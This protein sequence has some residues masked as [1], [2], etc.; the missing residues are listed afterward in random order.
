M[1]FWS[2]GRHP[3]ETEDVCAPAKTRRSRAVQLQSRWQEVMERERRA[4]ARNRR[5][6]QDFQKAQ[7]TLRDLAARTAAMATIRMEYERQLEQRFPQWQ[8]RFE[9][10]RIAAEQN[11]QVALQLKEALRAVKEKGKGEAHSRTTKGVNAPLSSPGPSLLPNS[12]ILPHRLITPKNGE[13]HLHSSQEKSKV[14]KENSAENDPYTQW[15]VSVQSS[16]MTGGHSRTGV[17]QASNDQNIHPHSDLRGFQDLVRAGY[18]FQ[19]PL[20]PLVSQPVDASWL[21]PQE[22]PHR[23]LIMGYPPGWPGLCNVPRFHSP[24]SQVP[25]PGY[26][27]VVCRDWGMAVPHGPDDREDSTRRERV[28]SEGQESTKDSSQGEQGCKRQMRTSNQSYELDIKPV[29]L[30]STQGDSSEDGSISS[31]AAKVGTAQVLRRREKKGRMRQSGMNR[32]EAASQRS[33]AGSSVSSL[34]GRGVVRATDSRATFEARSQRSG[35]PLATSPST[36]EEESHTQEEASG[37]AGAKAEGGVNQATETE[38]ETEDSS[39]RDGAITDEEDEI[40]GD[41]EVVE[42]TVAEK[43]IEGREQEM[44]E[45]GN[46]EQDV[47]KGEEESGDEGTVEGE[48]SSCSEVVEAERMGGLLEHAEEEVKVGKKLKLSVKEVEEE[49]PCSESNGFSEEEE[50]TEGEVE[51]EERVEENG[52]SLG[53]EVEEE[54]EEEEEEEGEHEGFGQEEN[55]EDEGDSSSSL[56]EGETDEGEEKGN[57]L[58]EEDEEDDED[59]EGEEGTGEAEAA[60]ADNEE[61]ESQGTTDSE[62]EII[63]SQLDKRNNMTR[64]TATGT[65]YKTRAGGNIEDIEEEDEDVEQIAED[66]TH[67]NES[68]GDK[69]LN[70]D[71]EDDEDGEDIEGLLAPRRDSSNHQVFVVKGKESPDPTPPLDREPKEKFTS[72]QRVKGLKITVKS[73]SKALWKDSDSDLEDNNPGKTDLIMPVKDVLEDFDEFYD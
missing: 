56:E 38:Q 17:S 25:W 35:M 22:Q 69:K 23:E 4:W 18:P 44:T 19:H 31:E 26:P 66:E 24:Y 12:P 59:D 50:D 43:E 62:D 21:L 34:T 37:S 51:V 33:S 8:Q 7:D 29:R 46:V 67:E 48:A 71:Y 65:S 70:D 39:Q 13:T 41:E 42:K 53:Q 5:L 52:S 57:D 40:D 61:E 36:G 58:V 10:K 15:N 6:L 9:E 30:S 14:V 49:D 68:D 20:N 1:A 45:K 2:V 64:K 3:G 16:W 63:T 32:E 28:R 60:A 55:G 72:P 73:T 11:E 54:E 27:I 47:H